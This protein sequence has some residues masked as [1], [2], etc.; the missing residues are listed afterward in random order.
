MTGPQM[1]TSLLRHIASHGTAKQRVGRVA[2][3]PVF[4]HRDLLPWLL[5]HTQLSS[6]FAQRIGLDDDVV[7]SLWHA[8]EQWDGKGPRP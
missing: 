1:A 4:F 6:A 8:Y 3:L 5:T 7:A 2:T